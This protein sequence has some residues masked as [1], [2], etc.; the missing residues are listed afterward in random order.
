MA[1]GEVRR[2][3]RSEE[4]IDPQKSAAGVA[5]HR[6]GGAGADRDVGIGDPIA[7]A[8]AMTDPGRRGADE[9]SPPATS[10]RMSPCLTPAV[11]AGAPCRCRHHRHRQNLR[12]PAMSRAQAALARNHLDDLAG[13]SHRPAG[14]VA[15]MPDQDGGMAGR[16]GA[17]ND[18][19]WA[20]PAPIR[21]VPRH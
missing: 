7:C 5:G 8:R 4:G 10:T 20:S 6:I 2:E 14:E 11:R 1:C 16:A 9:G 17:E 19:D 21:S 3:D 12:E 18:V 13:Q 15:P